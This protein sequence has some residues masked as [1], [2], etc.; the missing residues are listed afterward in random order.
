MHEDFSKIENQE[1]QIIRY[2][3]YTSVTEYL[4]GMGFLARMKNQRHL[5]SI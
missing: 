4:L 1:T 2:V 3:P 5:K